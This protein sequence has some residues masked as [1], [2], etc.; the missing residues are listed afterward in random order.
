MRKFIF[1]FAVVA[2]VMQSCSTGNM[3]TKKRY[4]HLK[5]IDHN[6]S[7]AENKKETSQETKAV[8]ERNSTV[9]SSEVKTTNDAAAVASTPNE[10]NAVATEKSSTKTNTAS[11]PSKPVVKVLDKVNPMHAVEKIKNSKPARKIASAVSNAKE[12]STG[13][14]LLMAVLIACAIVLFIILDGALR[15]ILSL[16]LIIFIVL[17]LLRYFGV[18]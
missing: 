2:L 18:I 5:W 14:L 3:F 16:I 17:V 1:L 8:S 4:G 13:E 12:G 6:T 9:S 7:V 15:G 10:H 11:N